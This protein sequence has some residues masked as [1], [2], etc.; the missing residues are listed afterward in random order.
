VRR[1]VVFTERLDEAVEKV[2]NNLGMIRS[3]FIR[4]SVLRLLE[5]LSVLSTQAHE[6]L[7]LR[8]KNGVVN[9]D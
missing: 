8:E 9:H 5:E 4:Y 1:S 3:A 7:P 6:Q 2:R